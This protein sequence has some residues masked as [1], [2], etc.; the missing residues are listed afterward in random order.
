MKQAQCRE[1]KEC[2]SILPLS[3]VPKGPQWCDG[4]MRIH[5]R[6]N[7]NRWGCNRSAQSRVLLLHATADMAGAATSVLD[8]KSSQLVYNLHLSYSQ[9]Y[10]ISEAVA[11]AAS[12]A[13]VQVYFAAQECCNEDKGVSWYSEDL[14]RAAF[15]RPPL[16]SGISEVQDDSIYSAEAVPNHKRKH[17]WHLLNTGDRLVPLVQNVSQA[18]GRQDA[19]WLN[20]IVNTL[21]QILTNIQL[22]L[23]ALHVPYSYGWSIILL[24]LLTKVFTFPFTKI[25]VGKSLSELTYHI[26]HNPCRCLN[27]VGKCIWLD[28]FMS[29]RSIKSLGHTLDIHRY[30]GHT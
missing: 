9:L 4:A 25:Q 15:A 18:S 23:D 11:A 16:L 5:C 30:S 14:R 6:V 22:S 19:G 28:L 2:E 3:V 24:T 26:R 7:S 10:N 8:S 20:P 21:D 29:S 12:P 13:V 17:K 27:A 1:A